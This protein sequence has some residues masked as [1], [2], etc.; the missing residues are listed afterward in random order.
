M[1]RRCLSFFL[2]CYVL[3]SFALDDDRTA[4]LFFQAD[5]VD[6]D[7]QTH[8]GYFEG[9]VALDQG[10]THLRAARAETLGDLQHPV[11]Q[12]IIYGNNIQQAH[13]WTQR[14]PQTLPL[15]AYADALYYDPL[16]HTIKLVG[17]AL[18]TQGAQRFQAPIIHYDIQQQR[19]RT[20]KT[21]QAR[22]TFILHT[23]TKQQAALMSTDFIHSTKPSP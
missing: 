17:H 21:A 19:V 11:T 7:Q 14:S 20:E 23:D 2:C 15:H 12:A 16:A 18:I 9:H 8:H 1:Y 10:R 3:V 4:P 6:L 13:Y 5:T 22:T